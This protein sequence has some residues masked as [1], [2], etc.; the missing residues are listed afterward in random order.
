[1]RRKLIML[2]LALLL[3]ASAVPTLAQQQTGILYTVQFEDTLAS[4]AARFNVAPASIITANNLA[5]P[6]LIFAGQS[7]FIPTVLG[8]GGP[9][10]VVTQP[11]TQP[12]TVIQTQPV[13][14]Q[15]TRTYVVQPG[16]T[17]TA[18]ANTFGTTVEEIARLNGITYSNF[19]Q[20]GQTL[21]VPDIGT[22]GGQAFGTGGPTTTTPTVPPRT[23]APRSYT[24]QLGDNLELIALDFGITP[25]AIAAANN[26]QNPSRIFP[27]Q[28]LAIP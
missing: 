22:G 20:R 10:T 5:N 12:I 1:M 11:Q 2:A 23:V 15:P 19:V 25:E 26:L 7:L 24:V 14:A 18:I 16:D 3:A 27:G 6:N 4:I 8:T 28:V 13:V 17:L 9:V 21:I